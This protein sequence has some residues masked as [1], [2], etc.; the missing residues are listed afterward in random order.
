MATILQQLKGAS[1]RLIILVAC[2]FARTV[3]RLLQDNRSEHAIGIA[4][5]FADGLATVEE[6]IAAAQA[7]QAAEARG[8]EFGGATVAATAAATTAWAAAN[9]GGHASAIAWA[10]QTATYAAAVTKAAGITKS[11]KGAKTV[12]QSLL[13]CILPS[14]NPSP[15]LPSAVLAWNGGTVRRLAGAIYEERQLPEGTLDPGRLA[16]LA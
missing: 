6:V 4:E 3:G 14:R 16:V 9:A 7:A 10:T 8:Q 1:P 13:D 12:C 11:A 5:Q 2:A 15:P